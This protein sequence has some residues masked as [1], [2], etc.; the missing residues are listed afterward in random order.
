MMTRMLQRRMEGIN[1]AL[2]RQGAE[3]IVTYVS[4]LKNNQVLE[5][6][7]LV[8]PKKMICPVIYFNREWWS[9]SD[10]E[11]ALNLIGLYEE[12]QVPDI[13]FSRYE[14]PEFILFNVY[15]RLYG[16]NN[17]QN[18]DDHDRFY[19]EYLD[20]LIGYYVVVDDL[21]D[22]NG[23]ASVPLTNEVIE[24]K[25]I[26]K[27]AIKREAIRHLYDDRSISSLVKKIADM[28]PIECGIECLENMKDSLYVVSNKSGING[29]ATI[30]SRKV[31]E[32]VAEILGDTYY[33]L[34]C[35]IH[36]VICCVG[37]NVEELRKMVYEA[38]REAV[39]LEDRLTDSVYQYKNGILDIVE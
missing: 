31:Q 4:V 37:H 39:L 21:S 22:K 38:N 29:A 26:S 30:L 9:D 11:V 12:K 32:A 10:D 25:G 33:V 28:L 20:M 27:E 18:M 8:S 7:N 5:G 16:C 23:V 6:Y 13:D 19:T 34:P 17:K 3:F 35:S 36:E 15:P 2:E 14:D 1:E 24:R